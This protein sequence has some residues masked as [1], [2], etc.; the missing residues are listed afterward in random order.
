MSK[1]Y[2]SEVHGLWNCTG[3]SWVGKSVS[4]LPAGREWIQWSAFEKD[5]K[6]RHVCHAVTKGKVFLR[7]L[8]WFE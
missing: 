7:S 8:V 3:C 5:T 6:P 1:H 4:E 2:G